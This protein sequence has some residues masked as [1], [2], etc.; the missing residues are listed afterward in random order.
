MCVFVRVFMR[1]RV[2]AWLHDV[3]ASVLKPAQIQRFLG[4]P[5]YDYNQII[6][7]VKHE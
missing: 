6:E 5:H 2:H 7:T 4:L 1:V 3:E